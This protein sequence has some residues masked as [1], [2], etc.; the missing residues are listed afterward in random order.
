ME[1]VDKGVFAVPVMEASEDVAARIPN[2]SRLLACV[3]E[4]R[5][6]LFHAH[7]CTPCHA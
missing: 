6:R 7:Y 3:R 4:G 2:V 1:Q 5:A